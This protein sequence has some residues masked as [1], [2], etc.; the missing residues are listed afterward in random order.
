MLAVTGSTTGMTG[1]TPS[2]QPP[3]LVSVP[4]CVMG[5]RAVERK[6]PVWGPGLPAPGSP[7]SLAM[8]TVPWESQN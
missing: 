4:G 8:G 7:R 2:A 1:P 3:Q 6:E 5:T